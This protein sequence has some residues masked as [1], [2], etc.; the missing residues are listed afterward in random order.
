MLINGEKQRA[1]RNVGK[2]RQQR[3][4]SQAAQKQS[5]LEKQ[6]ADENAR[7]AGQQ[8]DLTLETLELLV[9][10]IQ[11]N[12]GDKPGMEKLKEEILNLAIE[13]LNKIT[14]RIDLAAHEDEIAAVQSE[15]S[16]EE[17]QKY[18]KGYSEGRAAAIDLNL[19]IA[20]RRMG[21]IYNA[22]GR[23]KEALEQY[24]NSHRIITR[25]A[26]TDAG[27]SLV[28]RS[29]ANSHVK[30]GYIH[31]RLGQ[32]KQ[33]T[34]S[35][36]E[37]F[38]IREAVAAGDTDD[39]DG[40]YALSIAYRNLGDV[41]LHVADYPRAFDNFRRAIRIQRSLV[42]DRPNDP[43]LRRSL[44]FSYGDSAHLSLRIGLLEQAHDHA[45]R[46]LD[47]RLELAAADPDSRAAQRIVASGYTGLGNA[48]LAVGKK[49]EAEEIFLKRLEIAKQFLEADPQ[50]LRAKRNMGLAYN[51][52][53]ILCSR[54]GRV[55]EAREYFSH[56]VEF[57]E[58]V[59]KEAPR[60]AQSQTLL[61]AAYSNVA[62]NEM[63]AGNY[64][65]FAT[66]SAKAVLVE[67]NVR[68]QGK[69]TQ[70]SMV[71]NWVDA[72][73]KIANP[74]RDAFRI[75]S[76]PQF[77]DALPLFV[78]KDMLIFRC[79]VL[80]SQ[81]DL[82]A[83]FGAAKKVERLANENAVVWYDA[84]RCYAICSDANGLAKKSNG[85]SVDE[86]HQRC[87]DAALRC[88]S[89]AIDCGFQNLARL[90]TDPDL[91]SLRGNNEFQRLM[92]Q[93]GST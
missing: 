43:I 41:R 42:E 67:A 51:R 24:E 33:A 52:L 64:V 71:P 77:A 40:L 39:Q 65:G 69:N 81:G 16:S 25:L 85:E 61:A 54:Q 58:L 7:I 38:R 20:L 23:T 88:L 84:A 66:W 47:L 8:R 15:M 89:K 92:A 31:R 60:D 76:E 70:W 83:A 9:Y 29:L 11:D 26:S 68:V 14:R 34:K 86:L 73:L 50:S 5:E 46:S 93:M 48:L 90:Q 87:T 78:A 74:R 62:M 55:D 4:I 10:E 2:F 32:P 49:A 56:E 91:K 21:D 12:L 28:Q 18:I 22:T 27:W 45:R 36:E 44:A 30:L 79:T 17:I 6:R 82:E 80:A 19:A 37:S 72:P 57:K 63:R 53:G 59:A 3:D 1:D 35:Y 13:G 75:L